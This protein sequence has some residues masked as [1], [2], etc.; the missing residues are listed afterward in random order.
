MAVAAAL[1]VATAASCSLTSCKKD[2][3][4]SQQAVQ[5]EEATQTSIEE[6][7]VNQPVAPDGILDRY[8]A[9]FFADEAKKSATPSDSTWCLT[10]SGLKYAVVEPGT[11]ASPKATDTV[12]VHY[13]GMLTNGTVFDSSIQRGEEIDFPLNGVIKG[14]TEG[15]Q[16]MKAGG[17]SVFYIPSDLA[18][19]ERGAG[20]MIPPNAPL[21]FEV[22]L[23]KV[24]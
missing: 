17:I 24:N 21:I 3:S 9:A 15:L 8:N 23:I 18:Y 12:T 22:H 20:G 11:G 10:D 1:A 7:A 6:E 19:G 13:T 2:A 4:N 16:L 14:W 5:A